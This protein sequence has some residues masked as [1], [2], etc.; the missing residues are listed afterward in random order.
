LLRRDA[1]WLNATVSADGAHIAYLVPGSGAIDLY[2]GDPARLSDAVR[3]GSDRSSPVFLNAE[4]LWYLAGGLGCEGPA[5]KP[6]VYNVRTSTEA[7]SI[8]QFVISVWPATET[9]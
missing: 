9:K 1:R 6:R 3:I 8:V 2:I 7:A 5:P 4:Q